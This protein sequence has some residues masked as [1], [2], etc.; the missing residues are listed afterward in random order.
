MRNLREIVQKLCFL[1]GTQMFSKT[2]IPNPSETA[3]FPVNSFVGFNPKLFFGEVNNSIYFYLTAHCVRTLI[4]CITHF[5][6]VSAAWNEL[7]VIPIVWHNQITIS[8]CVIER[9]MIVTPVPPICQTNI[10]EHLDYSSC[11]ARKLFSRK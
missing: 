8:V 7:P 10:D 9:K 5:S 3:L 2:L 1:S 11:Y 4:G 6:G